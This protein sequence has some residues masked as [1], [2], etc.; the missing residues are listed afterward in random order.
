MTRISTLPN[1]TSTLLS[2]QQ[3]L[4]RLQ[5]TQ[6]D[7]ARLQEQISTGQAIRRVSDDPGQVASVL[8]LQRRLQEREQEGRN[9]DLA[10]Q[11]LNT[12][13]A[14][15][16][17]AANTLIEA[18]TIALS[19]IGVGSDAETRRAEAQV[20]DA[21]LTGLVD[22][23]NTQFNGVSVFGGNNGASLNGLVFDQFL[24]G[25]RY[26]GSDQNL[27]TDVGSFSS[28]DFT[29]QG[30]EAFG[31]FTAVVNNGVDLDPQASLNT[32]LTDLR[33][34]TNAGYVPGSIEVTVNAA[35]FSVDITEAD[36]L[37]DIA[38]LLTDAINNS[39]AG[40]GS[41]GVSTTGLVV[42]GNGANTVALDDGPGLR[43]AAS[44]G[45]A[46]VS[47]T[48]GTPVAGADLDARLTPLTPLANLNAS[49]DL[50]SGL[51]ITQGEQSV[52]VDLSSATT[53]QDLQ[54]IIADL[55]LG[56]R[57]D[58]A[59]DGHGLDF[60]STV[61]GLEFSV[62][63]NGGTTASDL[64]I[65]SFD[66][67]TPLTEFRHGLGVLTQTGEDDLAVAL[68][69]GTSFSVNL[70]DAT[71]V[72]QVV[73]LVNNAA[74]AAG[75]APGDFQFGRAATGTGFVA[76]DNTTGGDSFTITNANESNAA[77]HLGL[78]QDAG[79]ANTIQSQDTATRRIDNAFTD[80]ILLRDSLVKN[81]ESG[82]GVASNNLESD[83][84]AVV[85]GR[86]IVGVQ[87]QRLED[88]QLRNE[89]QTLQEQSLLSD[90]QDAD[91]TEV[92]AQYQQLQLQLQA[93]LQ[94]SA[95]IQQLN[96]LDFLR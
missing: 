14:A 63:E 69:D 18:K 61:A 5:V 68:H 81:D 62:G 20:I 11:T 77:A 2:S 16:G 50:A 52:T 40:A 6:K 96:L 91:L 21:Q 47:S 76:I 64:G 51:I 92:I 57:L 73:T 80:L 29:S 48:A 45:V 56:L 89:D 46:G 88:T 23:A 60:V 3:S 54:N 9:L 17:E 25:V 34:G 24:G 31:A 19:Q 49:I 35:T 65:H 26:I 79:N 4:G 43:T 7:L 84:D 94:T 15:L 38:T 75:V 10:T 58:I 90:L 59:E 13:D 55:D 72:G 8:L 70:D 44:L 82:I 1:R 32:R 30:G 27:Q 74:A 93:A 28:Q 86:A 83:I 12:A 53:I 36:T 78:V 37:E 33:G 22:I 71:N 87:A 95:Q 41:V 66:D 85:S 42:T 39:T 67:S